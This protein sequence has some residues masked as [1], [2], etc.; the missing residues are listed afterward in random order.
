[1][2]AL[3]SSIHQWE[4]QAV[5]SGFRCSWVWPA[6]KTQRACSWGTSL[7]PRAPGS[8]NSCNQL[9]AFQTPSTAISLRLTQPFERSDEHV[10]VLLTSRLWAESVGLRECRPSQE[11][12][13]THMWSCVF[14]PSRLSHSWPAQEQHREP[15]WFGLALGSNKSFDESTQVPARC[16][17]LTFYESSAA[18]A[19]AI[20]WARP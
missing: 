10:L 20:H 3:R 1:M 5:A 15:Y 13:I 19:V 2:I 12:K 17:R 6:S 16:P 7:F 14:G 11:A 18:L 4:S 9:S 8:P